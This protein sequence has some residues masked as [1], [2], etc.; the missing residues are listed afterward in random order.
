MYGHRN[1][2]DSRDPR[3][4]ARRG[5]WWDSLGLK[6]SPKLRPNPDLAAI[7][8]S[9]SHWDEAPE[10]LKEVSA[11]RA[12]AL[13]LFSGPGAELDSKLTKED[14]KSKLESNVIVEG[15]SIKESDLIPS[16]SKYSKSLIVL[17]QT[18]S[19]LVRSEVEKFF[20]S[21][22]Y[23]GSIIDVKKVS[24]D[25]ILLKLDNSRSATLVSTLDSKDFRVIRPNEY[26]AFDDPLLNKSSTVVLNE[27]TESPKTLYAKGFKSTTREQLITDL[28]S[29]GQ[30]ISLKLFPDSLLLL[31]FKHDINNEARIEIQSKYG[32]GLRHA[33]SNRTNH[34][35][36]SI[37]LA[38]DNLKLA[39]S[40]QQLKGLSKVVATN[41]I[42]FF[43]MISLEDLTN[44][45][46]FR[47]IF[48]TLQN[49][50]STFEGFVRLEIPQPEKSQYDD[51]QLDYGQVYVQF[52]NKEH[53]SICLET[54]CGRMFCNRTVFGRFVDPK[55]HERFN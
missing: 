53:A 32:I 36:Q 26:I 29:Y 42:E 6:C 52:D 15:K 5:A 19:S 27:I 7:R 39:S 46:V 4:R 1:N 13:G 23:Q 12:K 33:C 28:S 3:Q 30:L 41:M 34:Y 48:S 21:I 35:V 44:D 11:L 51:F 40:S 50:L 43:N 16:D 2:G 54:L 55:D 9:L 31:E 49:D 10:G 22:N 24:K 47:Y 8:P 37:R 45:D 20:N 38:N 17:K 14:L 18:D 25:E